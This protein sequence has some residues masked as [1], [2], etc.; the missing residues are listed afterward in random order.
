M[1][2]RAFLLS[3]YLTRR[4]SLQEIVTLP[5]LIQKNRYFEIFENNYKFFFLNGKK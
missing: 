3:I 1:A 4:V 2:P 5:K